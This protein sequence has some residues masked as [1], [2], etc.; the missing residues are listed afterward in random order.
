MRGTQWR[1]ATILSLPAT[2][3]LV[4]VVAVAAT[5]YVTLLRDPGFGLV[6]GMIPR[7]AS[8]FGALITAVMMPWFIAMT[9]VVYNSTSA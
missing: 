4:I 5:L 9:L 2:G 7:V 6:I 1:T 8:G 3:Y